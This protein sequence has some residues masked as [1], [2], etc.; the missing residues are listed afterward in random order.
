MSDRP[1]SLG[2]LRVLLPA[3]AHCRHARGFSPASTLLVGAYR[4]PRAVL[5]SE[6]ADVR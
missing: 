6:R 4:V 5:S 1:I 3:L 2:C